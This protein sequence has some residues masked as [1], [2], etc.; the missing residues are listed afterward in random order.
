MFE[1]EIAAGMTELDQHVPGWPDMIRTLKL[2][3][4]SIEWCVLGQIGKY[5]KWGHY[6]D[7]C[8]RLGYAP[9]GQEVKAHGF[10]TPTGPVVLTLEWITALKGMRR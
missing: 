2:D 10:Y 5:K 1:L 7:V 6:Y 4:N 8:T 3:M 9:F